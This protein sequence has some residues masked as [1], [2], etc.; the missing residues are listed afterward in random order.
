MGD[1]SG[2]WRYR[3]GDYRILCDIKDD[4][5]VVL[6]LEVGHRREVYR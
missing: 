6:A 5:L 2:I 4:E 1:K 3:V